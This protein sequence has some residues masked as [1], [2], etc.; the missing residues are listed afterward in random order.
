MPNPYHKFIPGSRLGSSI[1]ILAIPSIILLW[2]IHSPA[3]AFVEARLMALRYRF[4][5]PGNP[6]SPELVIVDVDDGSLNSYAAQ[7]N[8]LGRWPWPRDVYYPIYKHL[9]DLG[10][11]SIFMDIMFL[12]SSA[13]EYN[14]QGQRINRDDDLIAA[15]LDFPII[16]HAVF[17]RER[18]DD[19]S[20]HDQPPLTERAAQLLPR[21]SVELENAS[22]PHSGSQYR[23]LDLPA[24]GIAESSP[25]LH[26]VSVHPSS[27][28]LLTH[29]PAFC[30]YR[31]FT[32]PSLAL[33]A[34]ASRYDGIQSIK[35]L[36]D[37]ISIQ[38]RNRQILHW[39]IAGNQMPLHY[40]S[41]ADTLA[42]P[43]IPVAQI[44]EDIRRLNS[45]DPADAIQDF[46][47][48]LVAPELIA[49]KIV[50]FGASAKGAYDLLM[51]PYG[52]LPGVLMQAT[53]TSN[54]LQQD[55]PIR[56]PAW[57]DWLVTLLIV[58]IC[59][60]G[61]LRGRSFALAVALPLGLFLVW[62]VAAL[63]GFRLNVITP[64]ALTVMSIPPVLLFTVSWQ[65]IVEGREKR[66]YRK[67]LGSMVDPTIVS[68][69]LKDLEALKRG[70]ER[71]ITAFFSDVAGFSTISEQLNAAEL[72]DLLNE[73]LSAM[74]LVLK[75]H[76]GTLDKYIGDAVVGIFG[77][78]LELPN[79]A[80]AAAR[81]A[82]DMIAGLNLL[83]QRWQSG[84]LYCAAAQNMQI[85]IGLNSGP[86][87]V[88]FMGTTELASYTMMGDTVNL[89]ARLEAAAKDYGV[90]ILISDAVRERL[91]ADLVTRWLDIIVV[92]G[93]TEPVRVY[94]LIG[95]RALLSEQRLQAIALYEE[96]LSLYLDREWS[97]ARELFLQAARQ[98]GGNDKAVDMLA[99]RCQ[100]YLIQQ[101]DETWQGAWIRQHK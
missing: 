76:Q 48:L 91:S 4:F 7:S 9:S 66:K 13:D 56:L 35:L 100:S 23:Q 17:A 28:G 89:A 25:G 73:Y 62:F 97:R 71:D 31:N 61:S 99:E 29:M 64:M 85:R 65:I 53:M 32:I 12:E 43:R 63:I 20:S 27:T 98:N 21:F 47:Q 57:A 33:G 101:P 8:V 11:R 80:D 96:A 14:A 68:E 44:I 41:A 72:A 26:C 55:Q 24:P 15:N 88:G 75:Q 86:A 46:S 38:A 70:G 79:S 58:L 34:A 69:A 16:S 40:Y 5:N 50:I 18:N 95:Q 84:Q 30:R 51:T 90:S 94:E 3:G 92:K 10:A 74:T 52:E 36:D 6:I 54:L 19:A 83:R 49:N 60:L 42:F 82:L 59:A 93:K 78:P 81:T 2:S 39:S 22:D 37:Q 1:L 87:K 45:P 77:A 67:V